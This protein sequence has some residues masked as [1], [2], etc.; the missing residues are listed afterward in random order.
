M[1]PSSPNTGLFSGFTR[2]SKLFGLLIIVLYMITK[3]APSSMAY[4]ALVP[5]RTIPC[6]WNLVTSQFLETH[7]GLMVFDVLAALF[8][9]KVVEPIYGS[10]EFLKFTITVVMLAGAT[11]FASLFVAYMFGPRL[12]FIL[13][14]KYC[15]FQA[16]LAGYLVAV[17]QV[18]PDS[19]LRLLFVLKISAKY[20]PLI[21]VLA[22]SAVSG[23]YQ[24][25]YSIGLAAAGTFMSWIYLRF[26]Q[27][28]M[29]G[30]LIGD[31]SDEFRFAT[32]FPE[33]L[34]PLVDKLVM[35]CSLCC[36]ARRQHIDTSGYVM[37]GQP[38]PGSDQ[39]ESNRRRER[40]ARAL[41]ERL[42]SSKTGDVEA[43]AGAMK[44]EGQN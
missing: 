44:D 20:L 15:G 33:L 39:Q 27:S 30:K 41:E 6:V 43:A 21:Y 3:F 18:M 28:K 26:F 23:Y 37:Q 9:A 7:A 31:P 38:L 2:L 24:S 35:P 29:D 13:Y 11:V 40:G 12:G 42:G 5:G 17:K 36:G 34:H 8:L 22:V 32:F 14:G 19:E 16:V 25:F 4:L 1:P 10:K